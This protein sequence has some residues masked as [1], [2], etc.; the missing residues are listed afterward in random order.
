MIFDDETDPK[1]KKAKPR[2]LD[3]MSIEELRAYVSDLKNE[4]TRVEQ[5][6]SKR[7]KHK[8]AMSSLFKS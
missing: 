7:E 6:I 4:I 3:K 2:L 8:D 5:E 1:T